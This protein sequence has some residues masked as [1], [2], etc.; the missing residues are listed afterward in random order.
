M[1]GQWPKTSQMTKQ[2]TGVGVNAANTHR[3]EETPSPMATY[4][5]S[6]KA[7]NGLSTSISIPRPKSTADPAN[8]QNDPIL[9]EAGQWE[10]GKENVDK[11]VASRT[12][13]SK[14]NCLICSSHTPLYSIPTPAIQMFLNSGASEHCW[15]QRSDFV[16]YTEVHGQTGSSAISGEVG[17]FQI[18]GIGTVQFVTR[19]GDTERI[20]HLQGVRHTPAFGH[21]LI[22]LSTLDKRGM[23]GEW[24][25]GRMTVRTTTGETILEGFGQSKMYGVVI[26][27]SGET[28]TNYSR[29]R[30]R[31][32][33]IL[34]WH[35]RLGHISIR[36]ILR[37]SN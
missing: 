19:V 18:Q 13:V 24:G 1:E 9:R 17:T 23:R 20:V 2:N 10:T 8:R 22:S 4:V 28:T 35:R 25:L 6:I 26:L 15:V 14:A 31:P 21:N 3:G 27:E 12:T 32:V 30:D 11:D 36:R 16:E 33:D 34:T 37:M 7:G 5:M 29:A